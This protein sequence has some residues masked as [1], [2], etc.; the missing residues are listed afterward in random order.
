[1]DRDVAA[2]LLAALP[3]LPDRPA[4]R[5][6]RAVL[7]DAARTTSSGLDYTAHTMLTATHPAGASRV[8]AYRTA[9]PA[10]HRPV[11]RLEDVPAGLDRLAAMLTRH[12]RDITQPQLHRLA[13]HL[14]ETAG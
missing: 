1:M 8:P 7:L 13:L 5:F 3:A 11:H 2:V 6:T 12:P 14:G 10:A 4:H 9:E